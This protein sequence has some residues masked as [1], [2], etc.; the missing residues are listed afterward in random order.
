[1]ADSYQTHIGDVCR[2]MNSSPS[3]SVSS[4]PTVS[5]LSLSLSLS[6]Q[7]EQVVGLLLN[8]ISL[9]VPLSGSLNPKFLSFSHGE[10]FYS[11]FYSTINAELLRCLDTAVPLLLAA[12]TQ[13]TSMV[14]HMQ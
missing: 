5:P 13:N 3:Q 6:L 12:A 4:E 1:M 8:T 7:S 10:Y 2:E 9:S 14:K 11:L